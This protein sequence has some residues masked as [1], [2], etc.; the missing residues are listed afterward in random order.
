MSSTRSDRLPLVKLWM[1]RKGSAR[2]D[3]APILTATSISP[4]PVDARR[5]ARFDENWT[6]E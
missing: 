1:P 6:I 4:S 3:S 5:I 2:V